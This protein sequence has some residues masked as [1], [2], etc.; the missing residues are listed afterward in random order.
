MTDPKAQSVALTY[1]QKRNKPD[2]S[3]HKIFTLSAQPSSTRSYYQ[4]H[5]PHT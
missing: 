4:S 5:I 1:I 3:E 2:L